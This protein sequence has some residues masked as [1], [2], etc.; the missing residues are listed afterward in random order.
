MGLQHRDK[1]WAIPPG[2]VTTDERL[3]LLVLADQTNDD[4]TGWAH[5]RDKVLQMLGGKS[6]EWL[7]V[8]L[9]DLEAAHLILRRPRRRFPDGHWKRQVISLFPLDTA[10]TSGWFTPT[11]RAAKEAKRKVV[12]T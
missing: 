10:V 5:D 4:K 7:R 3:V 12:G 8:R 2:V 11:A 9:R 6:S 1:V